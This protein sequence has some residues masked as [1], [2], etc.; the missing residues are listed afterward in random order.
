V[1]PRSYAWCHNRTFASDEVVRGKSIV[2]HASIALSRALA[3]LR[4]D[5]SKPSMNQ[6]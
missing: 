6:P 5:A 2:G 1:D 3:S 4:S